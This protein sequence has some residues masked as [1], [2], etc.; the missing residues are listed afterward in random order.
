VPAADPG[1]PA[2]PEPGAAVDAAVDADLDT[3][4]DTALDAAFTAAARRYWHPVARSG[5]VGGAPVRSVLLGVPLV[6]WRQPGGQVAALV[7]RCP[8]RGVPLSDGHVDGAGHVRC[9]YHLWAFGADGRCVEV[10]Q[11]PGQPVP[12]IIAA[13]PVRVTEGAGLVW[14]CLVGEPEQAR[15]RPRFAEVEDLGWPSYVGTVQDWRA[16]AA[17]QIENFCDIGHFSVLHVDTFGNPDVLAVDPYTVRRTAWTVEADYSY[18]SVNPVAEPGPDGRRPVGRTD[19]AYR[20]EL[21]FA[22]WLGG[23]VGPDSVLFSVCAPTSATTLRLFWIAA[24]DPAAYGAG[25]VDGPAL[26]AVEDRIWAPD[27]RIVE[28]QRPVRVFATGTARSGWQDDQVAA[29][30]PAERKRPIEVH[31]AFDALGVAYRKALRDLGFAGPVAA[32][33]GGRRG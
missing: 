12:G 28:S 22:V 16:Q 30:P 1:A 3:A 15:D 33:D 8:H 32:M 14:A 2:G 21:P 29:L 23:A 18:P 4:L 9:A 19:F 5:D 26:Q 10:P 7:D 24:Y 20:I 25:P 27:Q 6:L 13:R 11:Q 31:R 17:R